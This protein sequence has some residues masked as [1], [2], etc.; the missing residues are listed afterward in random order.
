MI[1]ATISV[2][3]NTGEGFLIETRVATAFDNVELL[4]KVASELCSGY[5]RGE[6]LAFE[7]SSLS[8]EDDEDED[9]YDE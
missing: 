5:A 9:F 4:T 1:N 8:D 2:T 7:I 3:R 6:I